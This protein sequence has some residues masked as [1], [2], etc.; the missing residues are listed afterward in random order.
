MYFNSII[1]IFL[2]TIL[3]RLEI[4]LFFFTKSMEHIFIILL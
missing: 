1:N 4:G 2:Q 3:S